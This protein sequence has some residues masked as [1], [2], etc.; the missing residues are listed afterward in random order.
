MKDTFDDFS[1][2]QPALAAEQASACDPGQLTTLLRDMEHGDPSAFDRLFSIAYLQ[3]R[4]MARHRMSAS[5]VGLTL[6]PTGLVHETYL[7]MVGSAAAGYLNSRHFFAVAACAMRQIIIDMARRH[8]SAKR[9]SGQSKLEIDCD[10]LAVEAQAE[11]LCELDRALT[12]LGNYDERLVRVIE[13]RFFAG[14][15]ERETADAL[16]ISLSSVQRDW[17]RAKAWFAGNDASGNSDNG[18]ATG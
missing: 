9:G 11:Q 15:S 5:G 16:T 18:T 3:L 2:E 8:V 17:I 13:C 12:G 14:L 6:N 1:D 10:Q 4:T 7:K